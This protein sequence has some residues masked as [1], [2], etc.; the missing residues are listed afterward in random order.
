MTIKLKLPTSNTSA[1]AYI[2]MYKDPVYTYKIIGSRLWHIQKRIVTLNSDTSYFTDSTFD[3]HYIHKAQVFVDNKFFSGSL[4]YNDKKSAGNVLVYDGSGISLTYNHAV[5]T[6]YL[7]KENY[8][9]HNSTG[10]WT[11]YTIGRTP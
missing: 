1:T 9:G 4:S 6:A 7:Y 2:T 11:E 10:P 3:I 8:T 5:D